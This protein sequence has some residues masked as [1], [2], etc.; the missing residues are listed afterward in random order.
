MER[1]TR[2]PQFNWFNLPSITVFVICSYSVWASVLILK[3]LSVLGDFSD[4]NILRTLEKT[5]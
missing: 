2:R 4:E 1:G 5:L 3:C